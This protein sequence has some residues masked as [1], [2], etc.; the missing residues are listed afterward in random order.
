MWYVL[1]S[2]ILSGKTQ[3]ERLHWF[4][5]YVFNVTGK[6]RKYAYLRYCFIQK[7]PQKMEIR[8][9]PDGKHTEQ[10]EQ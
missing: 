10:L 1:S 2:I 7:F 9:V 4:A 3:K 8:Y 5:V 6:K